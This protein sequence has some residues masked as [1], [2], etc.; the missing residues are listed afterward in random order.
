M[1]ISYSWIERKCL[2]SIY[3][4]VHGHI[5][6]RLDAFILK[7]IP[8]GHW[9]TN[10]F[11]KPIFSIPSTTRHLFANKDLDVSV[12]SYSQSS[13]RFLDE[14]KILWTFNSYFEVVI[15]AALIGWKYQSCH[16]VNNPTKTASCAAIYPFCTNNA[17]EV[18]CIEDSGL[19]MQKWGEWNNNH[20]CNPKLTLRQR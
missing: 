9:Q 15:Y 8:S 4:Y 14:R 6:L 20:Y 17:M 5:R 16:D 11:H 13:D 7:K 1:Y 3:P 18:A 19:G 12:S 2:E 10:T